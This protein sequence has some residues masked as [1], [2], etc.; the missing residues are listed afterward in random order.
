MARAAQPIAGCSPKTQVP[1]GESR[2]IHRAGGRYLTL[3][4]SN[5][6]FH[7]PQDRWPAA[8]DVGSLA[9]E[10]LRPA[11]ALPSPCRGRPRI[12]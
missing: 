4:G 10:S 5:P 6:L 9:E 2:A 7:L 3:I 1:F 12:D 11:R 8:V